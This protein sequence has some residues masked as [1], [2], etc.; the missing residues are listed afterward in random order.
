MQRRSTH[1]RCVSVSIGVMLACV[2]PVIKT[3]D[4]SA[5]RAASSA[6]G[7]LW[8]GTPNPDQRFLWIMRAGKA[9]RGRD[10]AIDFDVAF[11][12]ALGE[13]IGV[14]PS[15]ACE[16]TEPDCIVWQ[17]EALS[18]DGS[19]LPCE[20]EIE[21]SERVVPASELSVM[22]IADA[23]GSM[24]PYRAQL[25]TAID[26]LSQGIRDDVG[27]SAV[28]L[29]DHDWAM[30]CDFT[31][32]SCGNHE[33]SELLDKFEWW[34]GTALWN[35]ALLGLEHLGA[36]SLDRER[37]LIAI[38]DGADNS[39]LASHGDFVE[40][41]RELGVQPFFI[42]LGDGSGFDE[43]IV[44]AITSDGGYISDATMPSLERVLAIIRR[45]LKSHYRVSLRLKSCNP[46]TTL[47]QVA[48][49]RIRAELPP[50]D[51]GYAPV[52]QDSR[53][54]LPIPRP[55]VCSPDTGSNLALLFER[56]K[57][58]REINEKMDNRLRAIIDRINAFP[59]WRL[60]LYG[61]ADG[62]GSAAHNA[63]LSRR[64]AE[65][66]RKELKK[67]G[68]DVRRIK[69]V[70]L[71]EGDVDTDRVQ[72]ELRRVAFRWAPRTK[73]APKPGCEEQP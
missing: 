1:A 39:S 58:T 34:G 48:G 18:A 30:A 40:K 41:A 38:S 42:D 71:G 43:L 23:S 7:S 6:S 21:T 44:A 67:R 11:L 52:I 20:L 9:A 31:D 64:R 29:F 17:V 72:P 62:P 65:F 50:D 69:V 27:H 59:G 60:E 26:F 57:H 19:A 53:P 61:E 73:D 36:E 55:T 63:S 10:L 49:V 51:N 66:V 8:E 54:F 46:D 32:P 12:D 15:H 13:P 70:A 56:D 16:V 24:E 14:D 22:L 4:S 2:A 47:E 5:R 28:A 33:V 35:A 3:Y 45:S 37:V 68:A 25:V